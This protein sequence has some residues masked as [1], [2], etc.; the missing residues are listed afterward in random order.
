MREFFSP[1]EG[2]QIGAKES[3]RER[4]SLEVGFLFSFH[5]SILLVLSFTLGERD[6]DQQ[7]LVR[8]GLEEEACVLAVSLFGWFVVLMRRG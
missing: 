1:S 6:V 2:E 7:L 4:P 3:A 5:L 8:V